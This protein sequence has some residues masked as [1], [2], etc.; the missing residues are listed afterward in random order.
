MRHQTVF[1][2]NWEVKTL[3][4]S[5]LRSLGTRL[6]D[7]LSMVPYAED[8]R[9]A[10]GLDACNG[11]IGDDGTYRYHVTLNRAPY[12]IG[13]FR[14][15]PRNANIPVDVASLQT[16]ALF[17]SLSF[18]SAIRIS[19][20]PPRVDKVFS[21]KHPGRYVAGE[22]I[23]LVVQWTTP[24]SVAIGMIG[25]VPQLPSLQVILVAPDKDG[26][27]NVVSPTTAT[28]V[29]DPT[30]STSRQSVF[31]LSITPAVSS[32]AMMFEFGF[33]F[34][35]RIF[36]PPQTT[37]KRLAATPVLDADVNLVSAERTTRFASKHQFIRDVQVVLR[38]L[39]HPYGEDLRVR[40]FH[41]MQQATIFQSCCGR[42]TF[43]RPDVRRRINTAQ[44]NIYP[45]NPTSGVGWD[46]SFRD[47]V[48]KAVSPSTPNLAK[49][50]SSSAIQ[51]ATSGR[52]AASY[53]ID[54]HVGGRVSD[55]NV[56]RSHS[57]RNTSRAWW[58]LRLLQP[59]AIGTIRIWFAQP[60]EHPVVTQVLTTNSADGI[61]QVDGSFTLRF[62]AFDGRVYETAAINWDAVAMVVD[63]DSRIDTP[64][65]GAGES[66]E[67]KIL[68]A[69]P[70]TS[71]TQKL[72]V[73]RNPAQTL[74][75][76]NGAFTWTITFLRNT[77]L[78]GTGNG[79]NAMLVER[80]PLAIGLNGL[81]GGTGVITLSNPLLGDDVDD[82]VYTE[83]DD[84]PESVKA[85]R[86]SMFPFWILLYESS[87][88]MDFESYNESLDTAVWRYRVDEGNNGS[89]VFT[90]NPPTTVGPTQY[91]RIMVDKPYAYL[92]LAEVEVFAERSHSLTMDPVGSP[93]SPEY[94]PG[95]ETWSPDDPFQAVFGGSTSEGTWTLAI[96]DLIKEEPNTHDAVRPNRHGA[97]A[98]SDWV[99]YI[100]NAAG[101]VRRYDLDV[102][103]RVQTLPRYGK[104]YV[105]IS[106]TEA[107]H[108]DRDQNGVL[109]LMEANRYLSRFYLNYNVLPIETRLRVLWDFFDG[110][111][112]F[113]SGHAIEILSDPSEREPLLPVACDREC[114][115]TRFGQDPYHYPTTTG[116]VGNKL[117]FITRD[118]VVRYIPDAGFLGR[119]VFTYSIS[120]GAQ[121]SVVRG[122]VFVYVKNCKLNPDCAE[123]IA[124]LDRNKPY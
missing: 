63:E 30:K 105:D 62:K 110:Y 65:R 102:K 8:G 27:S 109:D 53:A 111:S 78:Q 67:A 75:S 59:V 103:A 71:P 10:T 94:F 87:A 48:G 47:R 7:F 64:G 21:N 96:Q 91:L 45:E 54:G 124:T 92:T 42:A 120:V 51:S 20:T 44:I 24:V 37:I 97:G 95:P 41:E 114:L 60:E 46:Y 43:G 119:D 68:A 28:A 6:T 3:P 34:R 11:R 32:S 33:D 5:L 55:Q 121:E 39:Y 76:P 88:I 122:S 100:T 40:L 112:T 22:T 50:A 106:E 9:A 90:L 93:V 15:T 108:L 26:D 31:I 61:L 101:K 1:F 14:G 4:D 58:E 74:L 73:T 57:D 66:L 72:F 98:I 2:G 86:L 49:D 36:V 84:R 83:R 113:G 38:G 123:E 16:A 56:A 89:R 80:N 99:L 23:D 12:I 17:H 18:I 79:E 82:L 13:C 104:L 69:I 29:F 81:C 35:S 25:A 115:V 85:G 70:R 117:L 19:S 77:Y 52:C 107:D 118:R 116:D